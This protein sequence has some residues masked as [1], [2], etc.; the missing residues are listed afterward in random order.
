MDQKTCRFGHLLT[1]SFSGR[2]FCRLCRLPSVKSTRSS[3]PS[4][5]KT[6]MHY[7]G[8]TPE[9]ARKLIRDYMRKN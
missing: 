2:L 6:V 1:R 5:I 9:I 4:I 8:V 3:Q 7:R